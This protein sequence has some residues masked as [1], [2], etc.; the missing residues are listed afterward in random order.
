M[1]T[2]EELREQVKMTQEAIEI[3]KQLRR[4][5]DI[6][7]KYLTIVTIEFLGNSS[8]GPDWESKCSRALKDCEEIVHLV[9]MA[10]KELLGQ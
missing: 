2:E 9:D 8:K 10:K 4:E 1:T 7:V 6:A 5:R 3:I